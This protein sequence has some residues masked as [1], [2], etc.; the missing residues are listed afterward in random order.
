MSW[1]E[2]T[3]TNTR[4]AVWGVNIEP[5]ETTTQVMLVIFVHIYVYIYIYIYIYISVC[6]H[7]ALI[8]VC[9]LFGKSSLTRRT[10]W[11]VSHINFTSIFPYKCQASDYYHWTVSDGVSYYLTLYTDA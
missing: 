2:F 10:S 6:K 9:R 3:F 5:G 4:T 11:I 7:F 1:R 8:F